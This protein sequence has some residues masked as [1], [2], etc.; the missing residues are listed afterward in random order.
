MQVSFSHP[1]SPANIRSIFTAKPTADRHRLGADRYPQI[2]D[3]RR[4]SRMRRRA[5]GRLRCFPLP[6][7]HDQC[8]VSAVDVASDPGSDKN[9]NR[10]FRGCRRLFDCGEERFRRFRRAGLAHQR[11]RASL[12]CVSR[13]V[14]MPARP[15]FRCPS[16]S[17]VGYRYGRERRALCAR[18]WDFPDRDCAKGRRST[19]LLLSLLAAVC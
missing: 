15:V 14:S 12:S 1:G 8:Q 4:Q 19:G 17:I 10:G 18:P 9:R 5:C 2:V 13:S 7:V 16:P 11:V 6:S 3:L